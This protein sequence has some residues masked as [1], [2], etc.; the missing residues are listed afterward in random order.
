M[1]DRELLLSIIGGFLFAMAGLL[2]LLR[3]LEL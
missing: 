2:D 1:N 3:L